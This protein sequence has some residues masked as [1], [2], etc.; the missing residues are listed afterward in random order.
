[1]SQIAAYLYSDPLLEPAP[2]PRIWG[3]EV[4]RVYQDLGSRQQLEQLLQDCLVQDSQ[5][6]ITY[7]LLRHWS[8]LGDSL[9]EIGDRLKLLT[10]QG[11][12]VV[13]IEQTY[14]TSQASQTSQPAQISNHPTNPQATDLLHLLQEIQASQQSRRLKQGHAQNRLQ[15][16]PPPGKAPYGYRRGQDRYLIDRSTAPVIKEF[17]EYFLLYGSLRGAVRQIQKKYGKKISA[18][19][20]QRWLNNPV[21]RGHLAYKTGEVITNTHAPLINLEEAA[22]IDR[23]LR[24]NSRLPPRTASAPR[25]LAGLVIC[26]ECRSTMTITRVSKPRKKGEYLYLRPRSCGRA[27]KKGGLSGAEVKCGAIA[28][29]AVF[30]STVAKIAEDL[31]KAV[32]GVSLPNLEALKEQIT[33]QIYRNQEILAQLPELV[34]QGILDEETSN[35]RAYKL[36]TAISQLELRLA[37][38]PPGNLATIAQNVT[39]PQFWL[40]LSEAERRFYL[41]EFIKQV[42]INRQGESWSIELEFIFYAKPD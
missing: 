7:L 38:L 10:D 9:Q 42:V 29:D 34:T 13:A 20:G 35:L 5:E 12:Q 8:E 11:V 4:D 3:W 41:R 31:P 14:Q 2:D 6:K 24:R 21:Y 40:D 15:A 37:Q 28:Y 1:M 32:A 26:G 19:T 16:L 17:F 23:L 18:T 33:G 36:R 27:G 22:Q 39:L 25:S 30:R